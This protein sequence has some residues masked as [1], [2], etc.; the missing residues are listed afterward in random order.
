MR[1]VRMHDDEPIEGEVALNAILQSAAP[2][3]AKQWNG[4]YERVAMIVQR[5]AALDAT[6]LGAK[7]GF[8]SRETAIAQLRKLA[9]MPGQPFSADVLLEIAT[10]LERG[11][12]DRKVQCVVVGWNGSQIVDLEPDDLRALG[13]ALN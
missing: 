8:A 11:A 2:A 4:G 12:P 1:E 3:L 6:G 7:V 9:A 13:P 5:G 10:I